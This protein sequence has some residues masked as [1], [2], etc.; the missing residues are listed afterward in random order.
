[1]FK[2]DYVERL[3]NKDYIWAEVVKDIIERLIAMYSDFYAD[4]KQEDKTKTIDIISQLQ[5][6]LKQEWDK[7]DKRLI[8]K[9]MD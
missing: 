1:M 3:W 6:K 8:T 2:N 9:I 7:L 4:E 5:E